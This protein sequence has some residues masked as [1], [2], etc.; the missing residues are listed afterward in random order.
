MIC[1]HCS[2][3][4]LVSALHKIHD[5]AVLTEAAVLF[6]LMM[7]VERWR[8]W[9]ECHYDNMGGTAVRIAE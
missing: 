1:L 4:R 7:T 9:K 5:D 6:K 3:L 8:F 2:T